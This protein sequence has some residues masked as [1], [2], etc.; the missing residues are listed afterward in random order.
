MAANA[1]VILREME[2]RL[3]SYTFAVEHAPGM[4]GLKLEDWQRLYDALTD[5]YEAVRAVRTRLRPT[6]KAYEDLVAA[7]ETLYLE[8]EVQP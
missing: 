4:N 5:A 8:P 3:R 7:G 6:G 2:E 1:Y